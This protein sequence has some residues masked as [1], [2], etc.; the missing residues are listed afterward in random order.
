[1]QFPNPYYVTFVIPTGATAGARIVLN[2]TTGQIEIYN[3]SNQL[4]TTLGGPV[5]AI[6]NIDP[7]TG[8]QVQLALG[9]LQF[10][11]SRA[12]VS[13]DT[14][15]NA[16]LLESGVPFP[17]GINRRAI[18]QLL[19]GTT[20]GITGGANTPRVKFLPEAGA[21]AED[22]YLPGTLLY[23]DTSGV[24][25]T[26]QI[27]VMSGGYALGS[28]A[29]ALYQNLQY[30]FDAFD[31]VVIEGACHATS[32]QAAGAHGLFSLPVA[33]RPTKIHP[34]AGIHANSADVTQ[35]VIR[36]IADPAGS[37]SFYT[38]AAIAIND[39]FYFQMLVPRGNIS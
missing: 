5:G 22:L 3:S 34:T 39:N 29:S 12:M 13:Q 35:A 21:L 6:T 10:P 11:V 8:L 20:S 1:M 7:S 28:S 31:N 33:Y 25:T 15:T 14:G 19:Q 27:P 30:R 32:A 9:A 36:V 17:A 38:T 16:L 23:S 18:A 2:G 24:A 26:W 4:V 37:V